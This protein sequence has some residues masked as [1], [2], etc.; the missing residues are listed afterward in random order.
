M[1]LRATN[2]Y[3]QFFWGTLESIKTQQFWRDYGVSAGAQAI[4]CWLQ[5]I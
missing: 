1:K 4:S 5:F 3:I 2:L